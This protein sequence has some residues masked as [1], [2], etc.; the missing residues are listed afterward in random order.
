MSSHL[1]YSFPYYTLYYCQAN[2]ELL[3]GLID[4]KDLLVAETGQLKK[5]IVPNKDYVLLPN[6][7]AEELYSKFQCNH[8][9]VRE[10]INN[11]TTY[12]QLIS[13]EMFP[14][15]IGF[16]ICTTE[17]PEPGEQEE[18]EKFILCSSKMSCAQLV[19]KI[20]QE[21][22]YGYYTEVRLWLRDHSK[23]ELST[24]SKRK[25]TTD[26]TDVHNGWRFLR[27]ANHSATVSDLADGKDYIE[28]LAEVVK[29]NYP[30]DE[31]WP[32]F[33]YLTKWLQTLQVGDHVDIFCSK[34]AIKKFLEAEIIEV[35]NNDTVKVHFRALDDSYNQ[36]VSIT[37]NDIKPL[38][39]ETTN[40]RDDIE[41]D[42]ELELKEDNKWIKA[43]IVR[44]YFYIYSYIILIT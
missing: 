37:N 8:K 12:Q 44:N 1:Q 39:T 10:T 5:T 27:N 18:I 15:R 38:F 42:Q 30:K 28:A 32:R 25:L 20:K 24:H 13:V 14:I 41:E 6:D 35:N 34:A 17:R 26:I 36:D 33:K 4:T 3:P 19:F 23:A 43:T 9:I 11:G 31:E 21:C 16:H 7:C 29:S 40:W 22:N 2:D